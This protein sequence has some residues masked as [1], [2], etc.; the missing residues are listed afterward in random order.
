MTL[1]D[2]TKT[3]LPDSTAL[4]PDHIGVSDLHPSL[5]EYAQEVSVVQILSISSFCS[6]SQACDEGCYDIISS[7]HLKIIRDAKIL[8]TG[9]CNQTDNLWEIP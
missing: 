1:L 3:C 5:P 4:T 8:I 7:T 9:Y 6:I 2:P